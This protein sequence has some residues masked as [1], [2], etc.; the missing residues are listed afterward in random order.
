MFLTSACH[1][2]I[3]A[4]VFTL[5]VI[6]WVCL[7][8]LT[9]LLHNRHGFLLWIPTKREIGPTY[10][11]DVAWGLNA[12]LVWWLHLLSVTTYL[13]F[14]LL[15]TNWELNASAIVLVAETDAGF[16]PTPSKVRNALPCTCKSVATM[17]ISRSWFTPGVLEIFWSVICWMHINL[18][19]VVFPNLRTML[20]FSLSERCILCNYIDALLKPHF[21]L[22]LQINEGKFPNV[23]DWLHK[24]YTTDT[25]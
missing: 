15:A 17:F 1:F 7:I 6:W 24:T 10:W 8:Y 21:W 20:S 25:N 12:L 23:L 11:K 9:P 16:N 4:F 22:Y 19:I 13:F 3:Y 5:S 2:F 18:I 14:K